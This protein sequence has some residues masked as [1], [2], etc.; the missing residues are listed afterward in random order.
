[1]DELQLI[2]LKR[3]KAELEL[4]EIDVNCRKCDVSLSKQESFRR[5]IEVG[6]TALQKV[7]N[8]TCSKDV[9]GVLEKLILTAVVK[10]EKDLNA[11]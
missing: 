2:E 10:L 7:A 5:A 3:K 11:I 1:M 9:I 8:T 6:S 4:T